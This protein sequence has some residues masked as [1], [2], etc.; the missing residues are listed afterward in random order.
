LIQAVMLSWELP[1]P[2]ALWQEEPEPQQ[3]A[4]RETVR[5]WVEN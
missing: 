4:P 2:Q 1:V 3:V 5:E